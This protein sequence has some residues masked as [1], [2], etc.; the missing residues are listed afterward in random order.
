MQKAARRIVEKLRLHG[1]QAFFAGG[2]VRDSLL[3]RKSKDIDIATSARPGDIVRLF[4]NSVAIGASFGVIQ[5]REYGHAYEVAT[6]R[7]EKEYLDGRHPSSVTFT[8]PEEDA[9]RRDF[10]INGLFYDPLTDTL[11]DYVQG[12]A[13]IRKKLIRTI[14][15]PAARFSEDKLRMMRAIRLASIL[16]FK[17]VPETWEAIQKQAPEILQVSWERIRDELLKLLTGPAP[18]MGLDLL[19]QSGLL[20]H[21]LPEV[22]A[23]QGTMQPDSP[24]GM[25]AYSHTRTALSLLRKPSPVLALATLLHDIGRPSAPERQSADMHASIGAK[26]GEACCR[27][28]RMSNEEMDQI[29][30]LVRDHAVLSHVKELRESALIKFLRRGSFVDHLELHRVNSLSCGRGLELYR[31]CL[32]RL[33]EYRHKPETPPLLNGQDLIEMG[34]KP[35]P[36]FKEILG[37]IEDLQLEGELRSREDA[38]KHVRQSFPPTGKA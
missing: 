30:E 20:H 37:Q 38:K 21:I 7:K 27:R 18:G 10:T 32:Q 11:I 5:V 33:E 4:P 23:L 25:S 9:V 24:A 31:F 35:G 3:H 1:Y 16:G 36:V 15:N 28:L 26:L 8:G 29:I 22:E 13:D 12:E 2:W 14:G 6:F 19:N 17:I 34:Y